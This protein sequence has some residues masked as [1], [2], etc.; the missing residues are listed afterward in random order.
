MRLRAMP[1]SPAGTKNEDLREEDSLARLLRGRLIRPTLWARLAVVSEIWF[2]S[3]AT[4]RQRGF[5]NAASGTG[6][7]L[8]KGAAGIR[9][10]TLWSIFCVSAVRIPKPRCALREFEIHIVLYSR[11]R[12]DV[13]HAANY[14]GASLLIREDHP[15]R[16]RPR[17]GADPHDHCAIRENDHGSRLL[18]HRWQADSCPRP[19]RRK[20]TATHA[21]QPVLP[22]ADCVGHSLSLT[23]GAGC[24][25]NSSASI[26]VEAQLPEPL[27]F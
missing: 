10:F 23:C 3:L 20:R 8:L 27:L 1:A 6:K 11:H 19:N 24:A 25:G 15:I 2:L 18:V 4:A 26:S 5:G 17:T 7:S 13:H 14:V 9:R 12:F 21:P 16:P 22:C